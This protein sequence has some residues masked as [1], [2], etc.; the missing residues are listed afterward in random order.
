[1]KIHAAF[2]LTVLSIATRIAVSADETAVRPWDSSEPALS[3]DFDLWQPGAGTVVD[4]AARGVWDVEYGKAADTNDLRFAVALRFSTNAVYVLADVF[5]DHVVV[6]DCPA[7]AIDCPSWD[8]DNVEV[9]FDGNANRAADSRADGGADLVYGGEFSMM[10]NGAAMSGFSGYPKSFGTLWTGVVSRAR[11]PAGG[12]RIR[13][14]FRFSWRCLGRESPPAPGEEVRL[15][16]NVCVHDDDDG[17][18]ND[19]ALYL[20]GNP[21]RPYSDERAFLQI[22]VK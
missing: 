2:L 7:G 17:G 16:F 4:G 13:Y 10:A 6:D 3:T 9:F 5:D 11:S 12:E 15:G 21:E 8:D 19:H 1:M 22:L 14:A 20:T 18:R